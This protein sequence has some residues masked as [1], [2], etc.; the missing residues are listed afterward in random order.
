MD[1]QPAQ[2][3]KPHPSDMKAAI[4][5]YE[6]TNS[7]SAQEL[8]NAGPG[9]A[10][11]HRQS[12]QSA[13]SKS[14]TLATDTPAT[15]LEMNL[16][17]EALCGSRTAKDSNDASMRDSALQRVLS[18]PAPMSPPP[19]EHKKLEI[20]KGTKQPPPPPPPPVAMSPDLF[21]DDN[22]ST[23]SS[24][25]VF[26]ER[27]RAIRLELLRHKGIIAATSLTAFCFATYFF[28]VAVIMIVLYAVADRPEDRV[29]ARM[30]FNPINIAITLMAMGVGCS[31]LAMSLAFSIEDINWA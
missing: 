2:D 12:S 26:K 8:A 23:V 6:L 16:S 30:G 20:V 18:P 29:A 19:P 11:V 5:K 27:V 24:T 28:L 13:M 7:L 15:P 9:A 21:D 3:Q 22:F 31:A 14:P 25:T 10:A 1:E 4:G 17:K